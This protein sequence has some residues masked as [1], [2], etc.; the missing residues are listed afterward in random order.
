M[1]SKTLALLLAV[2][3][4]PTATAA[5]T[6]GDLGDVQAQT[7]LLRAKNLL[8]EEEKKYGLTHRGA[9]V[10]SAAVSEEL[11]VVARVSGLTSSPTAFLLYPDGGVVQAREGV[12]LR[13]GYSVA[14][15]RANR[16]EVKK[17]AEVFALGFSVYAPRRASE[18]IDSTLASGVSTLSMP[19][20]PPPP[21]P[22]GA[23]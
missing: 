6:V 17:G 14:S 15:I 2:T 19:P 5:E 23:R 11:P 16:V 21:P 12:R 7:Y 9:R 10:N 20:P 1:A 22:Q 18:A 3:I 13:G 4:A 8:A